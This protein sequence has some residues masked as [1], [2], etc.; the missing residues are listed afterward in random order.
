MKFQDF[1]LRPAEID[2]PIFSIALE[3]L[4][5]GNSDAVKS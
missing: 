3:L 2:P 4:T 1:I 5:Y